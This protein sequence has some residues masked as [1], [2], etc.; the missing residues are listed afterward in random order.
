[1][2]DDEPAAAS[3]AHDR[4][5][6]LKRLGLGAAVVGA[7][8]TPQVL[9]AAPASAACTP[10]TKM[11]QI[12]P[13]VCASGGVTTTFP[14]APEPTTCFPSGWASGRNDGV[15][16]TCPATPA[17]GGTITITTVGCTPVSARAILFCNPAPSGGSQY[18]CVSG[19]ISGTSVTFP[20][21][22]PAPGC[23]YLMFRITLSCC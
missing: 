3:G 15:T 19:T 23:F 20:T 7:W 13:A 5:T 1:M 18:S 6:L 9:A 11:L 14:T 2:I 21:S 8:T 16:Y 22:M 12:N 17:L 10:I 4:R